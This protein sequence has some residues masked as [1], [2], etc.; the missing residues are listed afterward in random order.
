MELTSASIGLWPRIRTWLFTK[1][2]AI[3]SFS[4]GALLT[5]LVTDLAGLIPIKE[6]VI[7]AVDYVGEELVTARK[8]FGHWIAGD[9]PEATSYVNTLEVYLAHRNSLP[10]D[11]EKAFLDRIAGNNIKW[12]GFVTQVDDTHTPTVLIIEKSLPSLLRIHGMSQS[13]SVICRLGNT[14]LVKV[15]SPKNLM[16]L[17]IEFA[18]SLANQFESYEYGTINDCQIISIVARP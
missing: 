4:V 6:L 18:G 2:G 3:I 15:D 16:W 17:K 5:A 8:V 10:F 11:E 12:V 7:E 1:T 9:A 14:N 13:D